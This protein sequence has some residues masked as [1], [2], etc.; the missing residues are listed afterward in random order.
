[1]NV[2]YMLLLLLLAVFGVFSGIQGCSPDTSSVVSA[3]TSTSMLAYVV[4]QAGGDR[5]SVVN[6]IP[7][8]QCPGHFDCKPSD[9]KKLSDANIFFMHNWQ[10]EKF[11]S[12]L[13]ASDNKPE[14][15]IAKID[16]TAPKSIL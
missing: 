5:L 10:G 6:I 9:I 13:M 14:L 3:V 4:E 2:K 11:T 1:M 8:G 16:R 7:P 15:V 12:D